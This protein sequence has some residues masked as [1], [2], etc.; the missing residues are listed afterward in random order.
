MKKSFVYTVIITFILASMSACGSK[1]ESSRDNSRKSKIESEESKDKDN[2]KDNKKDKKENKKDSHKK[3][4]SQNKKTD[5][6]EAETEE[7]SAEDIKSEG[8]DMTDPVA[9]AQSYI[10]FFN[11]V[12]SGI[13]F[14]ESDL[15]SVPEFMKQ[16]LVDRIDYTAE[17]DI[18]MKL[19]L[20]ANPEISRGN[21]ESEVGS[22]AELEEKINSRYPGFDVHLEDGV[23]VEVIYQFVKNGE[24]VNE[25]RSGVLLIMIDGKWYCAGFGGTSESLS[26]Y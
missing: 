5:K 25:N 4:D 12:E 13:Q 11:K 26:D 10:D 20:P 9:V 16:D 17:S 18:H 8:M 3:E 7:V 1:E 22:L 6:K 14:E 19:L 15:I 24:V 21:F 2:K 23:H